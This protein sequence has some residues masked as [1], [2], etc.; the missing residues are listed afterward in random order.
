MVAEQ[1]QSPSTLQ[2]QQNQPIRAI[3]IGYGCLALNIMQALLTDANVSVLAVFPWTKQPK[4][5]IKPDDHDKQ[6][7]QLAKQHGIPMLSYKGANSF[8][9]VQLVQS[10]EINTIFVGS[11]GEILKPHL[12]DIPGLT[13]INCHPSRLPDHRGSNPYASAIC[14]AERETAVTFHKVDPGIDTGPILLQR[15]L[16]IGP[17]ETGESLRERCGE[18]AGQMIP[19]VVSALCNPEAIQWLPQNPE[20]G[21]YF[22]KIEVKDGLINWQNPYTP[23]QV[24][25]LHPWLAGLTF[26]DVHLFRYA[27]LVATS[28]VT[29]VSSDELNPYHKNFRHLPTQIMPGMVLA[30][31]KGVLWLASPDPRRPWRVEKIRFF[32]QFGFFPVSVSKWLGY[33]VFQPG[34]VCHA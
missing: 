17:E 20:E 10:L 12:I 32:A 4:A 26:V 9:F 15:P 13:I 21:R 25:G 33:L 34:K 16:V 27:W 2:S 28:K 30:Y 14:M 19:D 18:L 23:F 3:V 8:D 29:L 5:G 11:W 1:Q 22:P 7:M 24:R 6:F 31:D